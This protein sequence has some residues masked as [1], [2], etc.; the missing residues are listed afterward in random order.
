MPAA[1]R[2]SADARNETAAFSE[3]DLEFAGRGEGDG[4]R[5]H[6]CRCLTHHCA[7][8][9]ALPTLAIHCFLPQEMHE[10]TLGC[11]RAQTGKFQITP[12]PLVFVFV[13]VLSQ[14]GAHC[15]GSVRLHLLIM[16]RRSNHSV[17]TDPGCATVDKQMKETDKL[18]KPGKSH[19][20]E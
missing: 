19:P 1:S 2:K 7:S 20:A 17:P 4:G 11:D 5:V 6:I 9:L 10:A 14:I 3:K 18:Q 16:C 8:L 12:T 15:S 13:F